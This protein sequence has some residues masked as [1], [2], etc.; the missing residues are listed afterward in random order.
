MGVLTATIGGVIR[1]VIAQHP[2]V[3]LRREIYVTAALVGAT[4]FVLLQQNGLDLLPAGIAGFVAALA[5]RG[6]AIALGLTLPGFKAKAV[7]S[8]D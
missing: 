5:L 4:V 3:L 6:C 7:D 2:S 8:A 1:D